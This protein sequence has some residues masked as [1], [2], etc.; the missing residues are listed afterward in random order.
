MIFLVLIGQL[1]VFNII[2]TSFNESR[3]W[4]RATVMDSM[5]HI[6][7]WSQKIILLAYTIAILVC[8]STFYDVHTMKLSTVH[9][10]ECI[11]FIKQT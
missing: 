5:D 6:W 4:K 11:L 10:S 2:H 7:Q 9:Y 8:V 3:I 1:K